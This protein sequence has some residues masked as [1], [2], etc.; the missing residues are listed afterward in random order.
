MQ[1]RRVSLIVCVQLVLGAAN[2]FA[3][4]TL[5]GFFRPPSAAL[6]PSAPS[7]HFGFD[8]FPRLW[9]EP[10]TF[11]APA[12]KGKHVSAVVILTQ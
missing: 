10:R 5:L 7:E 3:S 9:V 2:G 8:I 12:G 6:F 1:Y 4:G 11:G